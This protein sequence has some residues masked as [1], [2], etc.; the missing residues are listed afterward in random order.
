[1]CRNNAIALWRCENKIKPEV[2]KANKIAIFQIILYR[3]TDK[4]GMKQNLEYTRSH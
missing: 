3:K 4:L 1:M 2:K